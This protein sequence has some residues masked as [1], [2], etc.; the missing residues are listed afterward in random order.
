MS[1]SRENNRFPGFP[2]GSLKATAIPNLF[3]SA[4]LPDINDLA[5]LKLTLNAFWRIHSKRGYPRF[6]TL[7][8]MVSDSARLRAID[9]GRQRPEDV[10]REALEA[11]VNR[12]VLLRL[13]VRYGDR[14]DEAYFINSAEGRKAVEQLRQGEIDIGQ[15]LVEKPEPR[16]TVERK[17]IFVL[18]EQNIGLLTPLIAEQLQEAEKLYP[19]DWIEEA[20]R[21]AAE[22]NKRSWRYIQRILERW[23]FEGKTDGRKRR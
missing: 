3:F 16:A 4:L 22:Y 8:E 5:E 10:V 6:V 12:G 11:A 20:F 19:A 15:T 2:A 13:S 1:T 17:D 21:L 23:A 18:Y 9:D 7:R 14:V